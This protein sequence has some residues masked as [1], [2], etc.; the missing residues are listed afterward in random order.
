M[1]I[2]YRFGRIVV[3]RESDDR[4]TEEVWTFDR[5]LSPGMASATLETTIRLRF[6]GVRTRPSRRHS[7]RGKPGRS[8]QVDP[9]PRDRHPTNLNMAAA[10]V[11]LPDEV[12]ERV[13]ALVREMVT[14]EGA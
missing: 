8:W 1:K 12:R 10:D 14:L 13:L 4:L 6:Y 5:R 11:P 2:E 7:Y 9:E 3:S